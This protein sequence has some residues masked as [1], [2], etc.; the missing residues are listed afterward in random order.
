MKLMK[1]GEVV[2]I[3]G[4]WEGLEVNDI[5]FERSLRVASSRAA[6][7]RE[8]GFRPRT[9]MRKFLRR[10]LW[11][12]I[13]MGVLLG[14]GLS[15]EWFRRQGLQSLA[16]EVSGTFEAGGWLEG[17]P[18]PEA[19]LFEVWPRPDTITYHNV[20]RMER[21]GARFAAAQYHRSASSSKSK[22]ATY[23]EVFVTFPEADFPELDLWP[24]MPVNPLS[25]TMGSLI[26]FPAR[27]S[28]LI[29]PDA[30]ESFSAIFEVRAASAEKPET[31]AVARFLSPA[32]QEQLAGSREFLFGV[33][34][35]GNMVCL[36][37]NQKPVHQPYREMLTL[38]ERLVVIWRR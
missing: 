16:K 22:G 34:T 36:Q 28:P 4:E 24:P 30:I 27:T 14:I 5:V 32:V 31:A 2:T 7:A 25:Q 21:A 37:A 38:A 26:G 19:E 3:H 13:A 20:V 29:V 11:I 35:R 12:A 10:M 17:A 8:S 23:L 1:A 15:V 9:A 33:R 18:L 6:G